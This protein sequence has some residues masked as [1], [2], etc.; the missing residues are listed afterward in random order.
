M[1]G[2]PTEWFW[3][4]VSVIVVGLILSVSAPFLSRYL[5]GY[6]T[7]LRIRREVR[8]A[9]EKDEVDRIV[10]IMLEDSGVVTGIYS[11]WMSKRTIILVTLQ[12]SMTLLV[13]TFLAGLLIPDWLNQ[14]L[15]S[16]LLVLLL[17]VSPNVSV[18]F[19]FVSFLVSSALTYWAT[20]LMRQPDYRL[21]RAAIRLYE[22]EKKIMPYS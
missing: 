10:G 5:E 7:S 6:W 14:I 15:D 17:W 18:T 9:A 8:D 11:R 4:F 20:A 1:P 2:T 13:F 22:T 16:E 21:L 3:W 12:M 19:M